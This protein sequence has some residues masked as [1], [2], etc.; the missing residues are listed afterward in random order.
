MEKSYKISTVKI[1]FI[2][3]LISTSV[4]GLWERDELEARL[5]DMY[6]GEADEVVLF[7]QDNQLCMVTQR[8]VYSVKGV[9]KRLDW[10]MKNERL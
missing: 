10:I 5:P 6:S 4:L 1:A 2:I 8:A 7:L 9:N 3:G